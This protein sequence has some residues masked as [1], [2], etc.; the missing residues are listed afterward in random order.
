MIGGKMTPLRT[1]TRQSIKGALRRI[2]RTV[3]R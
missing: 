2:R 3:D 1:Y